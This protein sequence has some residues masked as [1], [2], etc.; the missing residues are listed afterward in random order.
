MSETEKDYTPYGF[1]TY[2]ESYG[3]SAFMVANAIEIGAWMA[4]PVPIGTLALH[5]VELSLKSVLIKEGITLDELRLKYGHDIKKLFEATALD[6]SDIDVE[7]I[8][9]YSDAVMCQALRYRRK[10]KPY[11]VME[12]EHLLPFMEKVFHRCLNHVS[13]GAKRTL[14]P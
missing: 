8:E 2:A 10:D 6:W 14:R 1:L 7:H 5:C 12:P 3:R 11:Y 13:H 9:F 4:W